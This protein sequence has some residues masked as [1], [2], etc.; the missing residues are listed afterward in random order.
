MVPVGESH[1]FIECLLCAKQIGCC[2]EN[3]VLP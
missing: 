3:G 2:E 1:E